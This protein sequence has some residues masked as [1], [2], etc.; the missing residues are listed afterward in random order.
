MADNFCKKFLLQQG[1]YMIGD[2]KAWLVTP[3][4]V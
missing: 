3:L 1:K 2:K 4:T